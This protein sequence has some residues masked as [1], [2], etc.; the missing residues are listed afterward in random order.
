MASIIFRRS[1][2]VK[3]ISLASASVPK[4][5]GM[6]LIPLFASN[7]AAISTLLDVLSDRLSV[8][9]TRIFFVSSPTSWENCILAFSKALS[10]ADPRG[11]LV[12]PLT[13]VFMSSSLPNKS[14]NRSFTLGIS[15]NTIT[16]YRMR[17][18]P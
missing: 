4:A 15:P 11:V 13:K 2:V 18:F 5:M 10:K 3:P 12:I 7:F 17:S 14:W 8:I 1:S 16:L 6:T 9:K